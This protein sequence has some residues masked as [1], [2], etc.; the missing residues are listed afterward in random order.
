MYL[1]IISI[2]IG[3]EEDGRNQIDKIADSK[4]K[5]MVNFALTSNGEYYSKVN[6]R[7]RLNSENDSI[8]YYDIALFKTPKTFQQKYIAYNKCNE[9]NNGE[10]VSIDDDYF[11]R[12]DSLGITSL[13]ECKDYGIVFNEENYK[14]LRRF[15]IEENLANYY[16]DFLG[17]YSVEK[18]TL[19]FE[20]GKKDTFL[21]V[22]YHGTSI[23][24][25]VYNQQNYNRY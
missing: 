8:F 4:F 19:S 18:G 9:L 12:M 1:L 13:D 16:V 6:T 15:R 24:L 3:C 2:F 17:L 21:L 11:E 10:E 14:L 23:K 22:K 7:Y 25:E 5:K 20:E